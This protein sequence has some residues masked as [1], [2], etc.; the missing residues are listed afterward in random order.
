MSWLESGRAEALIA[1]RPMQENK[2]LKS[3]IA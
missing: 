2:G 3:N 1:I